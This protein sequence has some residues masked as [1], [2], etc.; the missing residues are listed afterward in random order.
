LAT[1]FHDELLERFRYF[2]GHSDTLG[3]FADPTFL[4]RASKAVA[5]PSRDARVQKIAGIE[6]RGFVLG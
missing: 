2:D 4:A 6:A 1:D 5:A 3:L